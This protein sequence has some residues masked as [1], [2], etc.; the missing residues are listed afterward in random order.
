MTVEN[1]RN[2]SD[3]VD[4]L[5]TTI[6]KKIL[7]PASGKIEALELEITAIN[8]MFNELQKEHDLLNEAHYKTRVLAAVSTLAT[9]VLGIVLIIVVF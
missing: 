9:A 7:T 8:R 3:L 2:Q 5:A 4:S 6:Q 1:P